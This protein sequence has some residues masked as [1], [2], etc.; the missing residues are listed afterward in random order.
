MRKRYIL[1]FL[2]LV[3]LVVPSISTIVTA[4]G[5][6]PLPNNIRKGD[7]VLIK[8]K[9]TNGAPWYEHFVWWNHA[10]LYIG[11]IHGVDRVIHAWNGTENLSWY[12]AMEY[13]CKYGGVG[14]MLVLRLNDSGDNPG[15]DPFVPGAVTFA[16]GG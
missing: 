2:T 10:M 8:W 1:I 15:E 6:H 14:K 11:K 13:N 7:I 3:L 16:D 4:S 12:D 5:G 9:N